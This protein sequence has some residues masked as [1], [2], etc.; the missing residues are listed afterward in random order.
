MLGWARLSLG[1]VEG[2]GY[3]LNVSELAAALADRGVRVSYLRSGADY[4][5][6]PAMRINHRE[7]WRGVRCDDVFNSPNLA[8]SF[9]NFRNTSSELA[10]PRHTALV[11]KWLD[12]VGADVVHIHS[13]EGFG[14]DLPEAIKRSGRPLVITPHNHSFIC[15][16]VDLL[17]GEKQVCT[18]YDGGRRCETCV[19]PPSAS[20]SIFAQRLGRV[21]DRAMGIHSRPRSTLVQ[22]ALRKLSRPPRP[23]ASPMVPVVAVPT[24]A[25]ER[26]MGSE[27]RLLVLNNYGKRRLAGI[28][29]L[30]QA[31]LITPPGT[32]LAGVLEA[33]GVEREKIK[34]VRLGQPHFDLL[35]DAAR[36]SAGYRDVPWEPSSSRPLRFGFLGPHTHHKGLH[37]LM[38]AWRDS[39]LLQSRAT[40]LIRCYG[41]HTPHIREFSQRFS[42]VTLDGPYTPNALVRILQDVDVVVYPQVCFDNSPLVL[43]ESLH[44]GKFVVASDLGGPRGWIRPCKNGVL[45]PPGDAAGL[46]AVLERL[47][48]GETRLASPAEI[49]EATDLPRHSEYTNNLLELY[50]SLV[51]SRALD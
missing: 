18:D 6:K 10:C 44:A 47:V 39:S 42:S 30:R 9:F 24:D 26:L 36:A 27:R 21:L 46:R 20:R 17:Y 14:L 31:D 48:L 13:L 12:D 16:Q 19:H 40:L 41:K 5:F 37:V 32:W 28:A 22:R 49:H 43:L 50:G 51:S 3:N 7:V 25:G 34:I 2:S 23:P 45:V 33:F 11:L 8:P 1:A 15:P 29:A 38:D 35:N 4:S